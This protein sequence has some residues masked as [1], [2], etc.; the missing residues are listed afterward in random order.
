MRWMLTLPFF[1]AALAPALAL[2]ADVAAPTVPLTPWAPVIV[3]LVPIVLLYVKK[4]IPPS[5][6]TLIPV[7]A[8]VLGAAADALIAWATGHQADPKAGAIYGALGVFLREVVDQVR[9]APWTPDALTPPGD[10]KIGLVAVALLA[11]ML[12]AGCGTFDAHKGLMASGETLKASGQQFKTVAAAYVDGCKAG[13]IT[14]G[15][16]A[17]FRDFGQ[18]FEKAFPLAVNAWTIAKD[19]NDQAAVKS[20]QDLI[21]SLVAQLSQYTIQVLGAYAAPAGGK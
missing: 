12:L 19:A 6:T 3:A 8:P 16:C 20:A 7:L 13:T 4:A 10:R 5:A 17:R 14:P 11:P 9:K 15:Q 21:A 1:A 18:Q 2:A